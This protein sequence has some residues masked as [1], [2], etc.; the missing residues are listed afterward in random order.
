LKP[1][2][3]K[4]SLNKRL[5]QDFELKI[6]GDLGFTMYNFSLFFV[7]FLPLRNYLFCSF[8][9]SSERA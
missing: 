1:V 8:F 5:K 6:I 2:C 7:F 4:N 3:G 9:S